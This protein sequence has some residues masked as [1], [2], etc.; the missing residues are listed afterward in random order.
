MRKRGKIF[1]SVEKYSVLRAFSAIERCN[2][3]LLVIDASRGLLENDLHIAGFAKDAG[4]GIIIVVNKWDL[5]E[6]DN[7]TM[8][9][10]NDLLKEEFNFLSYAPIHLLHFLP[11]S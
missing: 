11:H 3:C 2:I 4:K 10:W 9:N 6:K 1:E 8:N 7:Y 5:V